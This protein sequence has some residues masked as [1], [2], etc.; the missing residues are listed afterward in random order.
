[1]QFTT[2]TLLVR[3]S[4]TDQMGFVHH[5]NYLR[6]FEIARLEWLKELG[7]SY[8]KMEEEKLLLPVAGAHI[9]FLRPCYFE[10]QLRVTVVL[11]AL[12]KAS[13]DFTYEIRN[14]HGVLVCTG[15]T[16][17]AFLDAHTG[18]P[19]RCPQQLYQAFESLCETE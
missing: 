1:M 15:S 14:Q 19:T 2:S 16:R 12:P 5:S 4:D 3:Y 13:L 11:E 6:Y 17:L 10:D 7:I 9:N 18:R 8:K